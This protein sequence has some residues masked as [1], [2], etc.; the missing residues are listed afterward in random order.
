MQFNKVKKLLAIS[1][2]A[3]TIK[4]NSLGV[5]TGILYLAPV[6]LSGFQVCPKASDGCKAACLYTAGRGYYQ[7][8]RNA[9][10][11]KTRWFFIDRK[12]FMETLVNDLER[13]IRKAKRKNMI[14]A[15]RL[16]GTSD[17]PWEKISVMRGGITYRNVMQA[18]REI[19]FY[20][21]TKIL[22]RDAAIR[23]PNYHLTFSLAENNDAEAAIAIKTGYNVAVVVN[24]KRKEIKPDTFAGYPAVDGDKSDVRF[25]DPKG[26]HFVLLTAK[27]EARKDKSGFVRDI[28][29]QNV[30]G[31]VLTKAA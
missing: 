17:I 15:A 7:K 27:G 20:D 29:T 19:M 28:K 26:G 16:N 8:T 14:P 23:E 1:A 21:Y 5:M 18:F 12:S 2:D 24:T 22:G 10:V 25:Y 9:R 31:N 3:K 11:N 4:G 13:L 30:F 6:N